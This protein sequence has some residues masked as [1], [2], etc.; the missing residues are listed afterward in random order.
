MLLLGSMRWSPAWRRA[1]PMAFCMVLFLSNL[2]HTEIK[3]ANGS[4]VGRYCLQ[5][6]LCMEIS[7]VWSCSHTHEKMQ[8]WPFEMYPP[9]A[10][11][12]GYIIS[13]DIAKYVV[14][15][16][17]ELSLQV[18]NELTTYPWIPI[19]FRSWWILLL[20]QL[21][22][23]EDVAMGI[24]IQQYKNSG[25]Q[26]NIVTDDRFYSEGCDADYVLAHYQSPRLMMCLW[27]KLK[28]EYQAVCCE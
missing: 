12:P 22:K 3:I 13:R 1:T 6:L 4:S 9:W 7:F 17:Q 19:V 16:H 28:T 11:G 14:K 18:E 24:W 26:V 10:H 21:F 23:L 20:S 5:Y 8:E 27:E 15:G 2:H 25:Q